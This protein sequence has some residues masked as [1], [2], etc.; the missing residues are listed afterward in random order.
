MIMEKNG[1]KELWGCLEISKQHA[2]M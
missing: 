1:G 2:S